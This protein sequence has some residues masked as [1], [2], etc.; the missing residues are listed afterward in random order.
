VVNTKTIMLVNIHPHMGGINQAAIDIRY[1]VLGNWALGY[2]AAR[3]VEN[4]KG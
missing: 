1:W 3:V 2:S 4:I